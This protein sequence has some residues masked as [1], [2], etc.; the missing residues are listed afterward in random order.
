MTDD[1]KMELI[2]TRYLRPHKVQRTREIEGWY[3]DRSGSLKIDELREATLRPLGEL[4]GAAEHGAAD[5]L[6]DDCD[7]CARIVDRSDCR[8]LSGTTLYAGFFRSAWGHFLMN[9]T[10]RLWPLFTGAVG[11]VDH[12]LFMVA[13]E[14]NIE[15]SGNYKEFFDLAGIADKIVMSTGEIAAER[16]LV[17]EIAFENNTYY[18]REMLTPF[19]AVKRAVSDDDSATAAPLFL[20]RSGL[21][22]ARYDEL[23]IERLDEL[24]SRNGYRVVSPEKISLSEL[25]RLFRTS[26]HIASVSGSIAHNFILAERDTDAVVIERAAVTNSYQVGLSLMVGLPTAFVDAFRLPRIA[27]STGQLFLFGATEPL[28]RFIAD[29]RWQ[30]HSFRSDAAARRSELRRFMSRFLRRYGH[31]TGVE[32]WVIGDMVAVGEAYLESYAYY[33]P[34]LDRRRLLMASDYLSPRCIARMLLDRLRGSAKV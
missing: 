13:P 30:S 18:T 10:A 6:I 24:F 29:R 8:R 5:L 15:L 1:E 9:S 11:S 14:D 27:P 20:T 3:T 22:D 16:L 2:D 32:S 19:D 31:S 33:R 21:P 25:I 12:I 23:N 26:R 28:E 7:Y 34:W 17:P 4:I